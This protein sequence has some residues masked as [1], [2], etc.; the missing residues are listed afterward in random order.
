MSIILYQTI[1]LNLKLFML[2]KEKN[3]LFL[4]LKQKVA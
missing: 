4:L 3:P 1:G 2:G